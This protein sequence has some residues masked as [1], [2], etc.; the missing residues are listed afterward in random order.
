MIYMKLIL[1]IKKSVIKNL[2]DV[3]KIVKL[4]IRKLDNYESIKYKRALGNIN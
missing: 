4:K 3:Y 2:Y 1:I